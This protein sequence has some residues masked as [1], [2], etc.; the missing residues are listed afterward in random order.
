MVHRRG[1]ANDEGNGSHTCGSCSHGEDATL[2]LTRRRLVAGGCSALVAG[3]AGCLGGGGDSAPPAPVT[4]TGDD[5]CDVCGM[6]VP[7]HPGPSAEIFYA[8]HRPSGHDDPARFDSTWEAFDYDF[9]R[10]DRG[11]SRRA[12]YVTDYSTV[13][14]RLL[15]R[16]GDVLVSTHPEADAFV[17]ATTVTFV[18]DSEVNGAMGRDLIGFS[19]RAD[20]RSFRDDHGGDL[21]GFG[22]VTRETIAALGSR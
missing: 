11:W 17:D 20:A 19:A 1:E 3:I 9:D 6:V 21:T 2:A 16:G 4:L 7:N 15:H 8:D 5:T 10:R 13:D 18:V 22:D 12:F 14:Y